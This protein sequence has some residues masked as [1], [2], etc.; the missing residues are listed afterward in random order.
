MPALHTL[1]IVWLGLS[2]A[3]WT[4]LAVAAPTGGQPTFAKDITVPAETAPAFTVKRVVGDLNRPWSVAWLPNGDMLITERPGRLLRLAKGAATQPKA[5][6]GLP[7]NI[8]VAGQGGLLDVAVH[9]NYAINQL[10]YFSYAEQAQAGT[11]TVLARARLNGQTLQ[12][13]EVVFRMQPAVSSSRHYGGRIVF[14]A[15]HMVYLTL[16]DRGQRAS[17][18]QANQHTGSV[19]RLHDDGRVP[20]DN[21]FVGSFAAPAESFSRGSRNIQGATFHPVTGELWTHEHGPQGGDEI[22]IIRAGKNYGWPIITY[23]V[24]YFTGTAIGQG[25]AKPGYEQPLHVWVPSVAPSGMTFYT[26]PHFPQWQ[27][28]LFVGALRGQTL[29]RLQWQNQRAVAEERLLQGQVGRIRDVRQGPDGY[30]YLLTDSPDGA[31]LRLEPN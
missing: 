4:P 9:P 20:A 8:A 3:C 21:P 14:D 24:N 23:G 29:I 26:G 22:N 12:D 7:Q 28:S 15:N 18:Q 19:I 11:R 30:L 16:G 6:S 1:A 13:L 27:G 17:A 2:L 10:I 25:V 5:L 31:L